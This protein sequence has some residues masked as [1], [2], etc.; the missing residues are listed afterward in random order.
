MQSRIIGIDDVRVRR[1]RTA[2]TAISVL[3]VLTRLSRLRGRDIC[4]GDRLMMPRAGS[5]VW[6]VERNG[7]WP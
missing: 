4:S 6:S 7:V 1:E 3:V 2:L 5:R